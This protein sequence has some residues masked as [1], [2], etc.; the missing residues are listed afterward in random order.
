M[1]SI[2]MNCTFSIEGGNS[3]PFF[4]FMLKF[5]AKTGVKHLVLQN[6]RQIFSSV[7]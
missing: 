5:T 1:I 4:G 2:N 3:A 7:S 6:F